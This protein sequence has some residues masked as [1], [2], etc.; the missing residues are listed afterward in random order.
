MRRATR[1]QP[2][3]KTGTTQIVVGLICTGEGCPISVEVFEGNTVD[4]TTVADQIEKVKARFGIRNVILAG[5]RGMI[6]GKLIQA[7]TTD[8]GSLS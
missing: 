3:R 2:G 4:P 7:Q 1:P 5:D 8:G 6:T